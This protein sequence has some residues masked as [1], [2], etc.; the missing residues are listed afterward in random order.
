MV[1]TYHMG[2]NWEHHMAV[3]GRAPPTDDFVCLS[4][5][6]HYVAED[7]GSWRGWEEVKG[8]SRFIADPG[9]TREAQVV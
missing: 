9:A 5:T 6:G 1:Y 3:V 7:A 2:D 8:V 4:G